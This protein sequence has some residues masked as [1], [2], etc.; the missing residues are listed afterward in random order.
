ME[1]YSTLNSMGEAVN[2]ANITVP[3]GAEFVVKNNLLV[4][5]EF[6]GGNYDSTKKNQLAYTYQIVDELTEATVTT[7]EKPPLLANST[8]PLANTKTE[9]KNP[10]NNQTE[11]G[12]S[13][14]FEIKEND[15]SGHESLTTNI[16]GTESRKVKYLAATFWDETEETNQGVNSCYALL[17]MPIVIDVKDDKKPT[18]NIIPFYWNSK[19]DSS[20][21]Y[22][23]DGNPLGHIDILSGND[24]PGVSGEVYIEG[25]A[26][27][28]T[29]LGEIWITEPSGSSYKVASYHKTGY[30]YS[31]TYR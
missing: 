22:D 12:V 23:D 28:D 20:F 4:V 6:V 10:I 31:P 9:V 3:T 17:K 24:N 26:R 15:L 21:V 16:D 18:A 2:I 19:E 13:K 1:Y 14:E 27:D 5:P 11:T 7:N 25:E 8:L 29:M 30:S